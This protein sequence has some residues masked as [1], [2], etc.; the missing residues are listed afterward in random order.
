VAIHEVHQGGIKLLIE[1]LPDPRPARMLLPLAC[2]RPQD[3]QGGFPLFIA[4]GVPWTARQGRQHP[5]NT[6][7]D[8][9]V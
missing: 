3:S 2:L 4:L 5:A 1:K 8:L 6:D 7:T 9:H